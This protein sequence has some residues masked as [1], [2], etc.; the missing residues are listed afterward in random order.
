MIGLGE[1]GGD[2]ASAGI[3]ERSQRGSP[4][5]KPGLTGTRMRLSCL[6]PLRLQDQAGNELTP[7]T[8]KARALL[9]VLALSS[10]P[11]S[12]ERLAD[13]LWSN[14]GAEQARSS[15]RQAVFELRH[16]DNGGAA[17]TSPVR[18]TVSLNVELVTT[19]L[20]AIRKAAEVDDFEGLEALLGGSDAGLLTDLDG[21]DPELDAWLQV[22]RAHEPSRTLAAALAAA[23]RCLEAAGPQAVNG[24]VAQVQRLDPGSEEAARLAMRIAHRQGDSGSLHRNFR[25]LGERLRADF[26]A[27]PSEETRRLF[28]ELSRSAAAQHG[29]GDGDVTGQHVVEHRTEGHAAPFGQDGTV[30]RPGW[31]TRRMAAAGLIAAGTIGT[32]GFVLTRDRRPPVPAEVNM[33]MDRGWNS[34]AQETRDSQN[35]AIALHQR[36]VTIAP[37]FA[38][39]WG[40]LAI[41]YA[42]AAYYRSRT[43][44][45]ALRQRARA[46]AMRALNL[47]SGNGYGRS[48]LAMSVPPNGR[49]QIVERG[50]RDAV[51]EHPRNEVILALLAFVLT[52]VGRHAE[53]LSFDGRIANS[54][55]P[56]GVLNQRLLALWSSNRLEE[57][58]RLAEMAIELYPHSVIWF[59]RFTI[60]MFSG[61]ARMAIALAEDEEHRP[62]SLSGSSVERLVDQAR[63]VESGRLEDANRLMA[64]EVARARESCGYA[65]SAIQIASSLGRLDEAFAL[66]EAHYFGRGFAG[67]RSAE[68]GCSDSD[69]EYRMTKVLFWPSTRLMRADPRFNRL[70]EELGLER[71]WR[72][73]GVQPDF[74]RS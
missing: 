22:E 24:I 65:E 64:A 39:G 9:A 20:W 30:V 60:L 48:A 17:V 32:A 41:A 5:N 28:D 15:F 7:R 52:C 36:V 59:T 10:R 23:E 45:D 54:S 4:V 3:S 25:L 47:D 49:W 63:T 50:L 46:A 51:D 62:A 35:Q 43:E 34:L 18:D 71:Y 26:D 13:L 42:V 72:E 67:G 27:E 2:R 66:A 1:N 69:L 12:R 6:G 74:R 58:D 68:T 11:S 61:R 14:R 19:D 57:T 31:L 73:V 56:P 33:L 40:A 16:L 8:R 38:D 37:D 44:S 70:T 53:A 29:P 55:P 21:L